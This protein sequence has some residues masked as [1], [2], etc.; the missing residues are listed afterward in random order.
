MAWRWIQ[1]HRTCPGGNR[2]G[3]VSF[4]RWLRLLDPGAWG[5]EQ[6]T[7]STVLFHSGARGRGARRSVRSYLPHHRWRAVLESTR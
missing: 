3:P 7:V 2:P 4:H 1:P 5:L 6:S